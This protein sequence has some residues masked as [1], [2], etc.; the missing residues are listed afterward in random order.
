MAVPIIKVII[1]LLKIKIS[2]IL[3]MITRLCRRYHL[4]H[5]RNTSMLNSYFR[6]GD[7]RLSSRYGIAAISAGIRW[8]TAWVPPRRLSLRQHI[9]TSKQMDF[10]L[11]PWTPNLGSCHVGVLQAKWKIEIINNTSEF[12]LDGRKM[13]PLVNILVCTW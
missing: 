8:R 13:K 7:E 12:R 1:M 11:S 5:S 3:P 4:F 6:R 10:L 9:C 2:N